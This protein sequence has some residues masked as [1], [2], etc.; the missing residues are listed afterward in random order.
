MGRPPAG[1]V[2]VTICRA[3]LGDAMGQKGSAQ[4]PTHP[5]GETLAGGTGSGL[6]LQERRAAPGIGGALEVR[7]GDPGPLS[8]G[9]SSLW[10]G[11]LGNTENRVLGG[12]RVGVSGFCPVSGRFRGRGQ[13]SSHATLECGSPGP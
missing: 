9:Q 1:E 10:S 6:L 5:W 12:L 11:H 2:G 8:L 7:P 3:S 4:L 13:W